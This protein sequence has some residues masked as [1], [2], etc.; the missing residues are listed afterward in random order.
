M[1]NC[2]SSIST[3]PEG[4]CCCALAGW[5]ADSPTA[6][7]RSR[8]SKIERVDMGESRLAGLVA[9]R[10][11]RRPVLTGRVLQFDPASVERAL[12]LGIDRIVEQQRLVRRDREPRAARDLIFQLIR[13]PA[14]IAEREQA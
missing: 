7:S 14:G 2:V 12:P 1:A 5:A 13:T 6:A 3:V 4:I 8:P 9:P 10:V 11:L